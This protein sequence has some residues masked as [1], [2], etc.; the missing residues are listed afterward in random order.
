LGFKLFKKLGCLALVVVLVF[1]VFPA[2][3]ESYGASS[4]KD[5]RGH[6][7]EQYIEKAVAQGIIKGYTDGR[8]LPDEKVS[9]AEF[10]SMINRALGNTST[11]KIN[12]SDVSSGAWYYGDVAKAVTAGFVSGF[13]DGTFRPNNK[14][15]RQEAAVMLARIVPTYGYSAN[16]SR[17]ADYRSIADWAY[18]AMS[19][20]CGKG[21]ISGYTD[22]MIHP[23]DSLTRAQ[24][25]KIISDIVQKE[26]VVTSDPVVKK[27]GT[28]LSGRIY[29]NNVTIHKDLDDGDATIENCVILGKL[30]VQGGGDDSITVNNSRI[31]NAVVDR[32][33]GSVRLIAKGE[34]A[35]LNTQGSRNFTLQ[36]TSLAGGA[37]GLGFERVSFT[38]SAT[39]TL[40]GN[41]RHVSIDGS[42]AEL[43]LVSGTITTLD[44][45]S[46]GRRSDITVESKA[47]VSQAN[48]YGE[49]Y[50]HGTGTI[51]KMDVY[52]KG[53][54]YE[55]KPKKWTIH[56]GGETPTHK[57][58]EL[59]ITIDPPHGE[60]GVYL[61]TKITL[62]FN[63]AMREE[64]GS[65]IT[66]SE[67]PDIV[68]IRKGSTS[69]SRVEYDGS[70]NS[71]KTVMTLTP[72]SLLEEKTRYYVIIKAGSMIDA[73]GNENEGETFY[74]TT[75][76]K[77]KK[78]VVTYSPAHGET[79]V[80]VNTK[81]FTITFSEAVTKYNG[82]SISTSAYDSYLKNNVVFFQRGSS[83]VSNSNYTVSINS[84]RTRITVDLDDD[85]NLDLN[86]KYTLGIRSSSLKTASGTNVP[87]SSASWTT[88]GTPVLSNIST[89]P[90][91]LEVAFKATPNVSGRMYAVLLASNAARP[92]AVQVRDGKDA[93]GNPAIAS[94]N[95]PV[96]AGNAATL[97]L[98]GG[99]IGRDTAYVVYAVLYDGNNNA[100]AVVNAS[101]RTEPLKLKLLEVV[102]NTGTWTSNVLTGFDSDKMD[103]GTIVVPNGTKFVR[104]KAEPKASL[105]S[106]PLPVMINDDRTT[107]KD[108]SLDAEGKATITVI[109]QEEGKRSVTYKVAVK[110]AGSA[111]LDS[112]TING[113][114]YNPASG[115]PYSIVKDWVEIELVI[116][117]KEDDATIII[118]G[119]D[120]PVAS[121]AKIV[122]TIGP[123]VKELEFTIMS[124]DGLDKKTYKIPF[125]RIEPE[126]DP[127]SKPDSSG[128][129]STGL[130]SAPGADGDSI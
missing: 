9:R 50:F 65:S 117:T 118:K 99:Q 37:F 22:G 5:I 46:S 16:L 64:D 82:G 70:I 53:V 38:S 97:K 100:S 86:T 72:K 84:A 111:D 11:G 15:T 71:A 45:S 2:G 63:S 78:L 76:T 33:A 60:T 119:E 58:P 27:D 1:L 75:G 108:I 42:S 30:I 21:Y 25:A 55:T 59:T 62:T 126:P 80:P 92:S 104:V 17:F 101:V 24:A 129:D 128:S 124:S 93:S 66:N 40:Q 112:I 116:T 88:A 125:N 57:D 121:G 91:E 52:A 74:F 20:V 115:I 31:A 3:I 89:V 41:F 44:V 106:G 96:T 122:L 98:S 73:D 10:I 14:I 28:K 12:F 56:S 43:R 87:A 13:D 23:L 113:V 67:I 90:Y 36:A 26:T 8:F 4:F 18:T 120:D 51:S 110:E 95:I 54:T 69:G 130:D 32:S 102:P 83:N 29:S 47:T 34:T 103:Y 48:V 19:K 68:T 109:V 123:E 39:G 94:T 81:R 79:G 85:Y 6:W 61:D 105:F 35:I 7:A 127:D 107:E 114:S 49:S 77:T